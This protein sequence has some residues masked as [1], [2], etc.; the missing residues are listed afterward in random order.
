MPAISGEVRGGLVWVWLSYPCGLNL[1]K[2]GTP[3]T[4]SHRQAEAMP[5][6][7]KSLELWLVRLSGGDCTFPTC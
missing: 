5:R 6:R 1:Y 7:A 2:V 4:P 3:T